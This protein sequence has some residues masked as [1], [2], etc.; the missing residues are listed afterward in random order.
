MATA[1]KIATIKTD[2][3]SISRDLFEKRMNTRRKRIYCIIKYRIGL[4]VVSVKNGRPMIRFTSEVQLPHGTRPMK[5]VACSV[6]LHY[7][8][9]F[10]DI[11]TLAERDYY[12][13]LSNETMQI[14]TDID[15]QREM[16]R[17]DDSLGSV[18]PLSYNV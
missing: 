13:P 12:R 15:E 16:A 2:M 10:S 3:S 1:K 4:E 5:P 18:D 11:G 8:A 17:I 9:G 14:G 6:K 7:K